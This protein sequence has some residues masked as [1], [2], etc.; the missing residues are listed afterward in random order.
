MFIEALFMM[1]KPWNQPRC[2]VI[3]EWI[4]R[5]WYNCRM[6]YDSSL[7]RNELSSHIKTWRHYKA[8]Y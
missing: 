2:P 5:L 7:I 3:D 1:A 8:Y 6:E 4:N